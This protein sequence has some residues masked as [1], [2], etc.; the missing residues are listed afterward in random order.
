MTL[1]SFGLR[2]GLAPVL[3]LALQVSLLA[4]GCGDDD[5]DMDLGGQDLSISGDG[6]LDNG[7]GGAP[8]VKVTGQVVAFETEAAIAGSVTV[9]TSGLTPPPSV[10]ISGSSFTLSDVLTDSVFSILAGS[11]PDY[12]TT[13]NVAPAV[14][15]ADVSGVKAYVVKETTIADFAT[16]FSVTPT[17]GKAVVF[18]H[19]V[20][21][22]GAG[23]AG[24]PSAAIQINGAA[25]VSGPHY[26]DGT[27][28]PM[29]GAG[30]TSTSG[31]VVFFNVD[32]GLVA[33]TTP[34]G[35]MYTF[36]TAQAPTAANLA[37]VVEV[38]ATMGTQMIPTNV[39]FANQVIPIFTSRGCINCHSGNGPG[40]DLGGLTLNGGA[41][42]IYTELTVELSPN[43]GTLRVDTAM[44]E[45]S[46]VLTRPSAENP[47][48]V[49]PTIVFPSNTDP[50]YLILLGWIKE[51]AK[52]N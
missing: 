22:M 25:P 44:P 7:D 17:A 39:S 31:W 20:D 6:F 37:T 26:L 18:A 12:R 46:L 35:S 23:V 30:M 42:K 16:G 50:D 34:M 36:A 32:P 10:S 28:M 3:A 29:A 47:P 33:V 11:P 13:Y 5:D 8:T 52:N 4:A 43:T 51:G 21:A 40:K 45:K 49:H 19:F 14:A 27:K 1:T 38:R 2:R 48:D 41:P 9:S 24:I 15:K